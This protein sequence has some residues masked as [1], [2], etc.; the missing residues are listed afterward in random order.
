MSQHFTIVTKFQTKIESSPLKSENEEDRI[1]LMKIIMKCADISNITRPFQI[2]KKW[3]KN[4]VNEFFVQGDLEKEKQLP[5]GILNDR[6]NLN[7]PKSQIGFVDFVAGT[8]FRNLL[9]AFPDLKE[10][11]DTIE[12]NKL[13]YK[14]LFESGF[15]S[16]KD[17][18][19]P[20]DTENLKNLKIEKEKKLNENKKEEIENLKKIEIQKEFDQKQVDLFKINFKSFIFNF[21]LN[22]KRSPFI[23][24]IKFKFNQLNQKLILNQFEKLEFKN[25][26]IYDH[27]FNQ[28]LISLPFSHFSTQNSVQILFENGELGSS[29]NLEST[30]TINNLE[31]KAPLFTLSVFDSIG[32]FF[33]LKNEKSIEIQTID[34]DT[35]EEIKFKILKENEKQEKEIENLNFYLNVPLKKWFNNP[36]HKDCIIISK[37][38]LS[39]QT[40]KKL[41]FNQVLK[42]SKF[43]YE[44]YLNQDFKFPNEKDLNEKLIELDLSDL[45]V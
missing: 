12:E 31:S 10:I 14:F 33:I 17:D 4:C 39:N 44:N 2:A 22:K 41:N 16:I 1:D 28:I 45:S 7:F 30:T 43:F 23:D 36:I 9:M 21:F 18:F 11:Y 42:L 8:L 35:K 3:A 25:F 20:T 29:S 32:L 15:T 5:V 34:F 19:D 27:L 38:D 37:N 40:I 24:E 6:N 26:L 13:H